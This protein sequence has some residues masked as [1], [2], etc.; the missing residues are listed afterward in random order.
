M[1]LGDDMSEFELNTEDELSSIDNDVALMFEA[2][3]VD[4]VDRDEVKYYD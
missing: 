2:G 3:S 1:L 4:N